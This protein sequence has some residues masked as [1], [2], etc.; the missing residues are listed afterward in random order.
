MSL[1]RILAWLADPRPAV[2][3][4]LVERALEDHL[5]T[6]ERLPDEDE[7]RELRRSVD[8]RHRR[9]RW[10]VVCERADRFASVVRKAVLPLAAL[11]LV[12]LH[13]TG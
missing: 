9:A 1:E 3:P 11:A 10:L 5:L 2:D 4:A 13:A 6:A 8:L 12:V 7:E